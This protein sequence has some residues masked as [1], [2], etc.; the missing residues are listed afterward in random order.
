MGFDA[1]LLN[2]PAQDPLAEQAVI[3]AA[4]LSNAVFAEIKGLRPDHFYR[5][6]H[7][8]IFATMLK[9][10]SA[11]V[12]ADPVSVAAELD[13]SGQLTRVGGGPYVHTLLTAVPTTTNASYYAKVVMDKWKIREVNKLGHRFLQIHDSADDIPEALDAARNFLDEADGEPPK[14]EG[15]IDLY[16]SWKNWMQAE[17][18][19]VPAPWD[20]LNSRIGGGF[21]K[22]H[23][24]VIGA[25]SGTGK[26][27]FLAN[28]ALQ[29]AL[30]HKR[31]AFFSLELPK[32]VLTGRILSAGAYVPY[33]E[34]AQRILKYESKKKLDRWIAEVGDLQTH[35]CIDD[36]CSVTIEDIARECRSMKR[37]GGLDAVYI[38][39]A[40]RVRPSNSKAD[41]EQQV[42]HIFIGAKTLAREANCPVILAAQLNRKIEEE[43]RKP[44]KSDFRESGA[45]EQEADVALILTRAQRD[46]TVNFGLVK[47]RLGP[48]E[49][50]EMPEKF[51]Y[52]KFGR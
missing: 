2:E 46:H 34:I 28:C 8:T 31:T 43:N 16:E 24:Y 39:Y 36:R 50:F 25:R 23:L 6:S 20:E 33:G 38:D 9:M 18:P 29:S 42:A 52:Q 32:E 22:Q 35:L 37:V 10:H 11:G 48:E 26:T 47:N 17:N 41:R 19:A 12:D 44:R 3:G 14:P 7:E 49:S 21:H 5:P 13:K 30:L 51:I 1:K 45:A 4:L 15:F 27:V 40:Q